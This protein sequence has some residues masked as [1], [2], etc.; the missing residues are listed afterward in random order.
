MDIRPWTTLIL[1][2]LESW[3]TIL[4]KMLPNLAIAIIIIVVAYF[5]GK[6]VR[7]ISFKITQRISKSDSVSGVISVILQTLTMFFALTIALGVLNLDKTVASLLAGVGIIGLALGFAFQDLSSNFI[8]GLYMAFRRPFEIGD[9]VE[10]NAFIGTVKNIELRSTTLSTTAGLY[11]I[12]PNKDIFQKPIIN[13][14]RS[15]NRNVELDFALPNTTE[16]TYVESMV[17]KALEELDGNA[18]KDIEFYFTAIE[19]P[20]IRVR[21]SFKIDSHEPKDFMIYRHKS[22]VSIFKMFGESNIVKIAV[23]A[24][25]NS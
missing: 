25:Q 6:L 9:K 17:R 5:I 24:P 14:S 18:V 1:E 13:Y 21:V 8:S 23:P 10:T 22:I 11:V 20:K 7:N 15:E 16:L 2:K 19:D 4:I 12:I 3:F